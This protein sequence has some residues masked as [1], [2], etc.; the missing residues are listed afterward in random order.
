MERPL[1]V[2]EL[3]RRL[4]AREAAID[5]VKDAPHG[6]ILPPVDPKR[7]F[8]EP[9]L[10]VVDTLN[11]AA[12][13]NSPVILVS[14]S[15]A[16]GKTTLAQHLARTTNNP[17]WD[18]GKF[19]MGSGFFAGIVSS[20]YGVERY[21]DLISE[22]RMGQLCLILDA[23]D[24]AIVASTSSNFIASLQNLA[25]VIR[26]ADGTHASA[27]FFGRPETIEDTYTYLGDLGIESQILE[28][29]YFSEGEAKRFVR[30]Q[31]A[32]A[33][34]N[35]ISE[36]NPFIEVFFSRVKAAFNSP[37]WA[38]VGSFLGYAPVLDSL[39]LFY[40]ESENAYKELNTFIADG[41]HRTWSLIGDMLD[42]V[43]QRETEKFANS[44]GG[45]NVAKRRFA[46]SAY[47][48][49]TQIR[50]LLADDLVRLSAE[51][52]LALDTEPDWLADIEQ[53]MR[54]QFEVHPFLRSV[55]GDHARN[56]LLGFTSAAFRDYV[57]AQ[58]LIDPDPHYMGVL[59]SYWLQ[60]EIVP[61]MM[62]SKFI[63]TIQDRS[64]PL[65]PEA[66]ALI[67]DSH[68]AQNPRTAD[69][70]YVE[71]VSDDEGDNA[72]TFDGSDTV[73]LSFEG[74]D[75]SQG[76]F[77]L[78]VPGNEIRLG[79]SAAYTVIA[80]P[81][82]RLIVG[83]QLAESDLGPRLAIDCEVFSAQS[84]EV[85]INHAVT[86]PV[87][88]TV[89][90]GG[91]N[92]RAQRVEGVVRKITGSRDEFSIRVP[93][94]PYPWQTYRVADKIDNEPA[95]ADLLF[96]GLALRRLTLRFGRGG[97]RFSREKMDAVLAKGRVSRPMFDF[98]LSRQYIWIDEQ[99]YRMNL[100]VAVGPIRSLQLSDPQYKRLL[101]E[102][103]RAIGS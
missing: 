87:P 57:L 17:Y 6:V 51:P 83:P 56:V 86:S 78:H 53:S 26:G 84:S 18:L 94:A 10:T 54:E 42:R 77:Q 27:I 102:A 82:A 62:L 37:E 20:A 8:I 21:A 89:K 12:E 67:L 99:N 14:A 34:H 76:S 4:P 15:A 90:R 66:M 73:I 88:G 81:Q 69:L 23:V 50:W 70:M 74:D 100:G 2:R 25:E 9:E 64:I 36:L 30:A 91:V 3:I 47:S 11:Y 40:R 48:S 16:V 93:V 28:V 97:M 1:Q 75:P 19:S 44:F 7:S 39:A 5:H 60:P 31:V 59:T 41:G 65:R 55:T 52:D 103:Y 85:H 96:V 38:V 13:T 22:I 58:F 24:E 79:R 63:R 92:I 46:A 68:S 61:S 72:I 43:L 32:A 33:N 45:E 95:E 49:Q 80:L 71:W 29:S 98:L 101:M 35:V